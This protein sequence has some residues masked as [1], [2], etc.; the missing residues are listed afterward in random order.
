M[1]SFGSILRSVFN[2][3]PFMPHLGIGVGIKPEDQTK[4]F[5]AFAQLESGT[6][7]RER[8]GLGLHL[9]QKL[10]TFLGGRITFQSEP[11]KG[12]VFAVNLN[13]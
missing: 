3:V 4:L 9:S 6:H 2:S 10:A 11:G 12:N 5:N 1:N 7:R 8:T 13:R